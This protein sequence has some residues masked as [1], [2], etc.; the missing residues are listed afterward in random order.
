MAARL[1][2]QAVIAGIL[3]M[4]NLKGVLFEQ[5]GSNCPSNHAHLWTSHWEGVQK[6]NSSLVNNFTK[7]TPT[8]LTSWR[9]N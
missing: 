2:V 5:E 4:Q 3:D 8:S 6:N 1:Q 7:L 9:T